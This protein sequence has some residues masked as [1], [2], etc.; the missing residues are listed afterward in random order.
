MAFDT[1][2]QSCTPLLLVGH[3]LGATIAY[4]MGLDFPDRIAAIV[5]VAGGID[6]VAARARWYNYAASGRLVRWMVPDELARANREI[7]PL[8]GELTAMAPLL[9][10]LAGKVTAIHGRRDKLVSFANLDY[11]A[12]Q[13]PAARTVAVPDVGHFVIWDRPELIVAEIIRRLPEPRACPGDASQ[14]G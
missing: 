2:N 3:S 1:L 13:I 14:A 6:P 9:G 12:A 7:M 5:A 11:V 4:R 10:R 8:E